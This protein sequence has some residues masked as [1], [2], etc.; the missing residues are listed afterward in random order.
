MYIYFQSPEIVFRLTF[1]LFITYIVHINVINW[2]ITVVFLYDI[3]TKNDFYFHHTENFDL[4]YVNV[5]KYIYI[6]I[7]YLYICTGRH[8][9]YMSPKLKTLGVR[10]QSLIKWFFSYLLKFQ[11]ANCAISGITLWSSTLQHFS[12]YANIKTLTQY[13]MDKQI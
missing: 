3:C 2:F 7:I 10:I 13:L 11:T 6:Y 12:S 1:G 5:W 8:K 4:L 9:F